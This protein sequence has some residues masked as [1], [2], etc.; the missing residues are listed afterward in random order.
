MNSSL[1]IFP[2][3]PLR[4]RTPFKIQLG[5]LGE[6]QPKSNV[7]HFSFI[8]AASAH[9]IDHLSCSAKSLITLGAEN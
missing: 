8:A 4:S 5:A 2:F 3:S 9:S 7:V 1:F 6:L